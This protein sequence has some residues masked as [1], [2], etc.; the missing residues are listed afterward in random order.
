MILKPLWTVSMVCALASM[1][2]PARA[3][4]SE[5][6]VAE[7][8]G[9]SYL[10][11]MIMEDQK[12]IEKYAKAAGVAPLEVSWSKFAGGNVMNDALLSNSLH[13]ASGGVA[14]LITLWAKTRT[15]YDVR[16]AAALNSMPLYLVTR[17]P[18]AKTLKDL[19]ERD[20]IALPAVK[21]SIQAVTL[22]MAAEQAFGPGQHD[23]LDALTV[24]MSHPDAMTALLSPNSEITGHFGSPPFQGYELENPSLHTLVNSYQVLGGPVTFNLVWTTSKFRTENPKVYG[25]FLKALDEATA[26]INK[27]KGW[28][29]DAYLRISKDKASR[30]TILKILNDPEVVF[31]TTPQNIIKYVSFMNKIGSIKATPAS[32]KDLFFPEAH[33]LSGS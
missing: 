30:A 15:N 12:L 27:D 17:N 10:P 26:L 22:Q 16:A 5:L 24:T 20:R 29:A 11:L 4:V 23:K 9:I 18:H 33:G 13:F 14:P 28:A 32:W 2:A 6:K 25:A 1:S 31:T 3:E 7:Q 8:Y 19:T 21:V